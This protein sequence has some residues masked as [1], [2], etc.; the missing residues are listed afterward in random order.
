MV[1]GFETDYN[2]TTKMYKYL[3]LIVFITLQLSSCTSRMPLLAIR[4]SKSIDTINIQCDSNDVYTRC[5]AIEIKKEYV[6]LGYNRFPHLGYCK[7]TIFYLPNEKH[8][9]AKTIRKSIPA[10]MSDGYVRNS[11]FMK[12]YDG[13]GKK[14][15]KK[16][17]IFKATGITGKVRR[18]VEKY[19]KDGKRVKDT[20][21]IK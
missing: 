20:L 8:K 15:Y 19:Y 13:N 5:N 21:S 16:I 12:G 6:Y 3:I 9:K 2:I 11:T 4:Y 18:D 17:S 10:G 7:K 14:M 1:G